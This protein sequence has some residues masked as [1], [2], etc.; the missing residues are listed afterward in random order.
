MTLKVA[1]IDTG[2]TLRGGQRQ[3]LLL[4]EGLRAH[5]HEQLIV[6]SEGGSLEAEALRLT[7][8]VFALPE[9]DPGHAFGILLLRRQLLTMGPHLVH[10]HDGRG[11]TVSWLASLGMPIRRVASRRVTFLPADSWT[12]RFKYGR[13]CDAVIAISEHI[14]E[15]AV[16]S[17]VPRER[18]EV[19]PDGIEVPPNLPSAADKARLRAAWQFEAGNFV[20]GQLGAFTPEKGHEVTLQAFG[21]IAQ[22]LPQARLVLA[23]AGLEEAGGLLASCL[24]Q[25]QDRVLLLEN[26]ASLSDL[27]P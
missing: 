1:H 23:G 16:R 10:A 15:L 9:H 7:L 12:F 25:R 11:Q 8:P 19:I 22:R 24:G 5:G 2:T 21:L 18:V 26:V 6:C 27:F 14:R 17:G 4:A 20:I 3:L 13:T